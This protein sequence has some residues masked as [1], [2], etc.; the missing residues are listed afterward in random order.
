MIIEATTDVDP[1]IQLRQ[2]VEA[3]LKSFEL[4]PT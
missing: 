2:D 3:M 4:N 1:P